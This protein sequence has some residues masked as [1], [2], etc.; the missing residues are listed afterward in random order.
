MSTT[1]ARDEREASGVVWRLNDGAPQQLM[2][3]PRGSVGV[4]WESRGERPEL[5]G[6]TRSGEV[7][8]WRE[9]GGAPKELGNLRESL[10]GAKLTSTHFSP[11]GSWFIGIT[12]Q[13]R[14]VLYQRSR[15]RAQVITIPQGKLTI[16][17]FLSLSNEARRDDALPAL[18]LGSSL[19]KLW[20]WRAGSLMLLGD[21]QGPLNRLT[22]SP[23]D[24]SISSASETRSLR[25]QGP[26]KLDSLTERLQRRAR[27]CVSPSERIALLAESPEEAKAS[28]GECVKR[29]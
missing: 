24:G 13:G 1:T 15:A 29:R 6:V 9:R 18:A 26:F 12:S 28:Y 17:R 16:A 21:H 8:N 19:G 27:L 22:I 20:I 14:G 4:A 23:K 5:I 3:L 10:N 7:W 2:T 25:W 11:D